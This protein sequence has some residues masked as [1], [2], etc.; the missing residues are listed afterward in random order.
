LPIG[1]IGGKNAELTPQI[2]AE[3]TAAAA[4]IGGTVAA[5]TGGNF[6]SGAKTAAFAE[7]FNDLSDEVAQQYKQAHA[8][9]KATPDVTVKRNLNS[10]KSYMSLAVDAAKAYAAQYGGIEFSYSGELPGDLPLAMKLSVELDE[11][12]ITP[13][14]GLGIGGGEAFTATIN[15]SYGYHMHGFNEVAYVAGGV[16]RNFGVSAGISG[17][18]FGQNNVFHKVGYGLGGFGGL[19]FQYTARP[20]T[21]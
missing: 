14:F 13:S 20:Y 1:S 15:G 19:I 21:I 6:V 8:A 4:I 10:I 18:L 2:V 16:N 3:R 9:A 7:M 17:N 5:A 11:N 12:G